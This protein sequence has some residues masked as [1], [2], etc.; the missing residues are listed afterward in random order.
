[1]ILTSMLSTMGS[2]LDSRFP[3]PVKL[4]SIAISVMVGCQRLHTTQKPGV[5]AKFEQTKSGDMKDQQSEIDLIQR[6][7]LL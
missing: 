5:A 2:M 6:L 1:M 3:F 7:Q 4:L